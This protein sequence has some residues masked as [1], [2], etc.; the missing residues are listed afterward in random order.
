[1]RRLGVAPAAR[2]E[3]VD[4]AAWYE[5]ERAGLGAAFIDAADAVV[6]RMRQTPLI[7][8]PVPR[9]PTVRRAKVGIFPYWIVF[10]V[11]DE[12]IRI[13]AVAHQHRAEGYWA[14]RL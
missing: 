7:F 13:V 5:R 6:E 10:A 4:A 1:M 11:T 2:A 8:G 14:D 3:L 12:A 9:H